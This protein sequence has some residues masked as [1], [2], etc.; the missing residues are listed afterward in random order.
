MI[1]LRLILGVTHNKQQQGDIGSNRSKK[2]TLFLFNIDVSRT[3][4]HHDEL[5]LDKLVRRDQTRASE[6][7][8]AT[9]INKLEQKIINF[10]QKVEL[11]K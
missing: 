2:S 4:D 7:Y 3:R 9:R 11:P 8:M 10:L 6:T 5:R 1:F